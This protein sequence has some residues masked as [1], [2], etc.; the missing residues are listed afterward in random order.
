MSIKRSLA[1]RERRNEMQHQKNKTKT[2]QQLS[3]Y[4]FWKD[5]L[6][7]QHKKGIT[8]TQQQRPELPTVTLI[9]HASK[10]KAH[11]LHQRY[12]LNTTSV[13]LERNA[14]GLHHQRTR[15]HRHRHQTRMGKARTGFPQL[16]NSPSTKRSTI[17]HA[18]QHTR[19]LISDRN[20]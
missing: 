18:D 11:K 9:R 15:Q 3:C 5:F 20:T 13:T 10:Y 14:P 16:R 7:H 4:P 17:S 6:K 1:E 19:E 12:I 8:Q 2:N